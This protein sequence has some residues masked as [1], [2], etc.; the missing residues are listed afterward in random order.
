MGIQRFPLEVLPDAPF[1]EHP[2]YRDLTA[3]EPKSHRPSSFRMAASG[4]GLA[5][6]S[7]RSRNQVRGA[8][9]A[10]L[11]ELCTA[12]PANLHRIPIIGKTKPSPAVK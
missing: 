12:Y 2:F 4:V 6:S 7:G 1:L 5:L 3:L 9:T 11:P 10:F 8:S